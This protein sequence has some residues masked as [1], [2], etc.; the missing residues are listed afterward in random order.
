M[1]DAERARVV[2]ELSRRSVSRRS[3]SQRREAL[4]GYRSTT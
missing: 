2:A 4:D 3:V 1:T